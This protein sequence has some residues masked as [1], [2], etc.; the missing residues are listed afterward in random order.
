MS[1]D[2]DSMREKQRRDE[3]PAELTRREL[4]ASSEVAKAKS[5]MGLPLSDVERLSL[6]TE[7]LLDDLRQEKS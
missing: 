3:E 5:K 6:K 2:E 4:K 1:L 7:K